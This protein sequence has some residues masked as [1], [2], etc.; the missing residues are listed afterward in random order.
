MAVQCRRYYLFLFTGN[1]QPRSILQYV[2]HVY[3]IIIKVY[4]Q[5]RPARTNTKCEDNERDT[6]V[7]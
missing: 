1:T 4:Q 6:W 7:I 5:T 2:C 3:N